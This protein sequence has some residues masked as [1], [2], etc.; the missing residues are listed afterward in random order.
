MWK[1][2][3]DINRHLCIFS[4]GKS[5]TQQ[6]AEIYFF[7]FGNACG[8]FLVTLIS[9]LIGGT[10]ETLGGGKGCYMNTHGHRSR[11]WHPSLWNCLS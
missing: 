3:A 8:Y 7:F 9:L 6:P 11:L 5:Q 10:E 2:E 4:K 1:F